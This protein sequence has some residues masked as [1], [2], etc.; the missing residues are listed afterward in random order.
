MTVTY[1]KPEPADL[2]HLAANLRP[3][4]R[5]EA[6]A[7]GS[8]DVL[9][10]LEKSVALSLDACVARV[11]GDA[12]CIFGLGAGSLLSGVARPWMM[13]TPAVEANARI[14]LRSNKVVVNDWASRFDLENW[15]DA[16]HTVSVRWLQWLGFAVYEPEPFGPFKLP[17]HRFEMRRAE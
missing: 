12:A 10:R 1:H 6:L 4:D 16:R 5:E 9:S 13:G 2:A 11:D 14:F 8:T 15:V 17:F 7:S 3:A